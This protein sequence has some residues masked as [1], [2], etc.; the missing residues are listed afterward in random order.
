MRYTEFSLPS[1]NCTTLHI[2]QCSGYIQAAK[3]F[4]ATVVSKT[5]LSIGMSRFYSDDIEKSAPLT[6]LRD[7]KIR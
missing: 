5:S 7:S 1:V 3:T 4:I 2:L 6:F